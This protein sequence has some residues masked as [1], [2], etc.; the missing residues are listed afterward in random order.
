M[1][2]GY[3]SV[4]FCYM[5]F[6]QIEAIPATVLLMNTSVETNV[7]GRIRHSL[8]DRL[9]QQTLETWFSPIQFEKASTVL[10]T[11]STYAR[12]TRSLKS[13]SSTITPACEDSLTLTCTCRD[14]PSIG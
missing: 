5:G 2:A 14:T 1:G 9:N 4:R 8:K 13:G 7:W 3:Q 11:F 12:R 10:T 6:S